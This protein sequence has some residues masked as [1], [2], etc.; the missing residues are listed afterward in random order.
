MSTTDAYRQKM[1]AELDKYR[2][3]I[4]MLRAQ[5]TDAGADARIE[6]E[7]HLDGLEERRQEME[8]KLADLSDSSGE[9]LEDIKAGLSSAWEDLGRAVDEASSRFGR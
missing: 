3:R 8:K 5:A 7:R 1:E 4:Q 9:A 6:Y 2:A